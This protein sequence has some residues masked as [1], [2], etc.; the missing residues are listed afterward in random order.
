MKS[1]ILTVLLI[2]IVFT[3]S[4]S[5]VLVNNGAKFSIQNG[6][7]LVI[8]GDL[9]NLDGSDYDNSGSIK[10][11]GDWINSDIAEL[12]LQASTG[13]VLFAGNSSQ[14][15]SGTKTHF[16]NLTLSNN[17]ELNTEIS[18]SSLLTLDTAF[19][20]LGEND[21]IMDPGSSIFGASDI[22]YIKAFGNGKLLREVDNT[23][24]DFPV[25]NLLSYVPLSIIN[26]GTLDFFGVNVMEDVLENGTY[27]NT[28]P[29]IDHCVNNTW[30][31]SEQTAGGSDLS[32]TASWE[33]SIEGVSF[34][35]TYCGLG[36]YANSSW[37]PI[38]GSVATGSN[39]FSVNRTGISDLEAFAVGDTLSPMAIGLRLAFDCQVFLE[40]PFNGMD[41]NTDLNPEKLPLSQ[42]Y[43]AAPWFYDG[44]ESVI[45]LPNTDIV[46]WVLIELRDTTDAS[47]ATGA[48][49]IARKAGFLLKD[50]SIVATDGFSNIQF[51]VQPANQLFVIIW[52]RNHLGILSANPLEFSDGVYAY[53]FTTGNS[54]AFGTDGQKELVPGKWGMFGGDGDTDGNIDIDDKTL[55]WEN[56]AGENAYL[57]GDYNLD[58]EVENRDKNEI[59]EQNTGTSS[60]IPE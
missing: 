1:I 17:V 21:L 35:R 60:Q 40:G 34:D 55:V 57:N 54:Q 7:S 53:N 3:Q 52:H 45:S 50:G 36:I 4:F 46:D 58:G 18:V 42:P 24:T 28:I 30:K 47:L 20:S 16:S 15:I 19:L 43:S 32:V 5:Q 59:W 44:T 10:I 25:G 27:G 33:T 2:A 13:E 11:L 41:M 39:L 48:T 9:N 23:S 22:A 37:E 6:S 26:D 51:D 8:A 12:Q 29:E 14:H 49:M 56:Q 31:I 38:T